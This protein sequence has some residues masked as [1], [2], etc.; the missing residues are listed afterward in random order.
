MSITGDKPPAL[1][2][3]L[4]AVD[5]AARETMRGLQAD[6][7]VVV[8]ADV[9]TKS[10]ATVAA[11][12]PR[13]SRTAT[14]AALTVR[15]T[16]GKQHGGVT[17]AEVVR[18]VNRGTGVLRTGPGPKRPIRPKTRNALQGKAMILP[19]GKRRWKVQGQAANPFME[20]IDLAGSALF[21]KAAIDG[22]DRA[23]RL[24]VQKFGS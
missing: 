3:L 16:R 2:T 15:P 22:A 20:R 23:L 19:G 13:I 14:G 4:S 21:E 11:L 9:P 24:V 7:A 10:G 17:V 12:R 6:V 1:A 5:T 8:V 18:W